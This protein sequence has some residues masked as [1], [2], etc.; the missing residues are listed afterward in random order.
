MLAEI[1]LAEHDDARAEAELSRAL[2]ALKGAEAPLAEW[3]VHETAARLRTRR[4]QMSQARRH[5]ARSAATLTRLIDSLRDWP[6]L[7][8]SLRSASRVQA[9]LG[10]EAS[11]GGPSGPGRAFTGDPGEVGHAGRWQGSGRR[12]ATGPVMFPEP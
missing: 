9:I 6:E 8:R 10:R 5:R 1:A 3:R 2:A 7:Q 12:S 11:S 4:K